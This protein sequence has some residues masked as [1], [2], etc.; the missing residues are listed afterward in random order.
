MDRTS[1]S[2]GIIY[3]TGTNN[4][5][6]LSYRIQ[7]LLQKEYS[8]QSSIFKITSEN[9]KSIYENMAKFEQIIFLSPVYACGIPH[10]FKKFLQHIPRSKNQSVMVLSLKGQ[11][12]K[13]KE[14]GHSGIAPLQARRLLMKKGY[15]VI[16]AEDIIT[17]HNVTLVFNSLSDDQSNSIFLKA[18][19]KLRSI[20]RLFLD[21]KYQIIHRTWLLWVFSWIFNN[22]FLTIGRIGIGL[23]FIASPKCN[24]CNI[25]AKQC[26]NNS[27]SM[28]SGKPIWKANCQGCLRCYNNC[29]QNAI[30]ISL[31]RV[32]ILTLPW[33]GI[34]PISIFSLF[35]IW[36]GI[37]DQLMFTT[38][39]LLILVVSMKI[40]AY[41]I[42]IVV[43]TTA[44]YFTLILLEKIPFFRRISSISPTSSINRYMAKKKFADE[45]E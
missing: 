27:I 24:N 17:P 30:Q 25:C 5:E 8:I 41:F 35:G 34:Y 7:H 42:N 11:L 37:I 2:C 9:Q 39:N 29:P 14:D 28:K 43:W 15:D 26:P 31:L 4:S 10:I 23:F 33:I 1:S 18:D 44:F 13:N 20:I 36:Q 19:R 45:M 16:I 6:I 22:L 38:S 32:I 40:F 3:F 12:S 21:K